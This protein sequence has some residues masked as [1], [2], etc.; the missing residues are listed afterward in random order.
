MI[1]NTNYITMLY[2]RGSQSKCFVPS[3]EQLVVTCVTQASSQLAHWVLH[4]AEVMHDHQVFF[5]LSP[6]RKI[7]G[8]L[9]DPPAGRVR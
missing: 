3:I 6:I 7:P 4:C 2:S 8:I 1:K 5:G 9:T